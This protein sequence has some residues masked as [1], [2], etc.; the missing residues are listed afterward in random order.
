MRP[1]QQ[2]AA[3]TGRGVMMSEISLIFKKIYDDNKTKKYHARA[4]FIDEALRQTTQNNPG[5]SS[6][7]LVVITFSLCDSLNTIPIT[8]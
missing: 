4:K 8:I 7:N 3:G 6:Q 2:S 1:R 5:V